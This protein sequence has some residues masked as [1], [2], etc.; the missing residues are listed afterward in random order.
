MCTMHKYKTGFNAIPYK[1]D[2]TS[3]SIFFGLL[4]QQNYVYVY[5]ISIIVEFAMHR[6]K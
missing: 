4:N 6:I 2:F 5:L 1:L 3:L